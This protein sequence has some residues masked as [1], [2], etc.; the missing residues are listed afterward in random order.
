MFDDD[1]FEPEVREG[2]Y[3]SRMMK[4]LWAAQ[5]IVL[6]HID[7]VC[8][9]HGL[10]WFADNGTLLGAV[11]HRGYIPWDDDMDICMLRED[12]DKFLE[13]AKDELPGGYVIRNVHTD[14]ECMDL[15]TRILNSGSIRLDSEFLTENAGFPYTAG[16]DIFPLDDISEDEE[17]EKERCDKIKDIAR[18]GELLA[19]ETYTRETID[20]LD[21][22]EKENGILLD[23]GNISNKL[24]LALDRLY[25]MF[26]GR[27]SKSVALVHYWSMDMAGHRYERRMF[28]TRLLLTLRFLFP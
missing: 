7:E 14:P 24:N 5:I 23:E 27:H 28:D 10:R 21:R 18:L 1:F 6:K 3:I 25:S 19:S 22:V 8:A 15:T 4:R 11:R 26:K 13:V 9:R 12:Y 20:L 17:E 2:F 16:I